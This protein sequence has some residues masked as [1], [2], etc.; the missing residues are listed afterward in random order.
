[1]RFARCI[2]HL[3]DRGTVGWRRL[4]DRANSSLRLTICAWSRQGCRRSRTRLRWLFGA[5]G[6]L[7]FTRRMGFDSPSF[8]RRTRRSFTRT[9]RI[10]F[11]KTSVNAL[12]RPLQNSEGARIESQVPSLL[13]LRRESRQRNEKQEPCH[14]FHLGSWDDRHCEPGYG[15]DG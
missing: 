10:S 11:R 1:L 9:H 13:A 6:V 3:G 4:S 12:Q 14:P 7:L 15:A 8:S 5:R 2:S